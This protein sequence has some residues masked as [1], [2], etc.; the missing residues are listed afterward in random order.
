MRFL[1]LR[2]PARVLLA[3][4]FVAFAAVL[5]FFGLTRTQ[6][7]RDGL[8]GQIEQAFSK[9]FRGSIE[10]G[11][12]T[13]NLVYDLYATDVRLRDPQGRVVLE[14]DSVVLEPTWWGIIRRRLVLDE[15]TLI[16]PRIDLVR[17]ESGRWNLADVF[18]SRKPRTEPGDP[19]D[20]S[21]PAIWL[22]DATL[23]T[24]NEGDP[25]AAVRKGTLFDYTAATITH[26]DLRADLDWN[27]DRHRIRVRHLTAELTEPPLQI[28]RLEGILDVTDGDVRLR[29]LVLETDASQIAGDFSLVRSDDA[30]ALFDLSLAPSHVAGGELRR[31]VPALPLAD[32]VEIAA[33]VRGPLRDLTVE[34]LTLARGATDLRVEGTLT[35][36]PDSAVF[37]VTI[38][39]STVHQRD[40]DAVWPTLA[41]P[42]LHGLGTT[43]LQLDADGAY[44]SGR[45]RTNARFTVASDAGRARGTARLRH[46]PDRPLVY[47]LDAETDALDPGLLLGDSAWAGDVSGHVTLDGSGT[48]AESLNGRLQLA[49]AESRLAGRMIDTLTADVTTEGLR[50]SGSAVLVAGG[51]LGLDGTVDLTAAPRF[52][53]DLRADAFDL[54]RLLYGAPP[55]RLTADATLDGTGTTLDDFRGDLAVQFAPST[56]TFGGEARPI[57]AHATTLRLRPTDSEATWF[58]LDSDLVRVRGAGDVEAGALVALATQWTN[59]VARTVQTERA[60]YY[61]TRPDSLRGTV[62]PTTEPVDAAPQAL[63]VDVEIRQP[64]ALRALLPGFP[65]FAPGTALDV[66]AR[67]APDSLAL[68]ASARGDSLRVPGLFGSAF[69][70]TLDF[71]SGYSRTLLGRSRLDLDLDADTLRI[72]GGLPIG[73]TAA[74]RLRDREGTLSLRRSR[75]DAPG[76]LVLDADLAIRPDVNRLTLHLVEVAT[77]SQTWRERGTQTVDLYAD[78]IVLRD[79]VF[80]REQEG[81][82]PPRLAFDGVLSTLDT[83]S[84]HVDAEALD[85]SELFGLI[86]KGELFGGRLDAELA[87]VSALR[88]P[89]IVGAATIDRF[90]FAG[91]R[92]GQITLTSQYVPG[93]DGVAVDLHLMPD[94]DSLSVVN[95]LR[96]SGTVR[97]PGTRDDGSRDP[98]ALDL[99][100][101]L[102]RLD[103]FV[104]DWLFPS[105]IDDAGG[106]A[107][108]TGRITGV[109]RVPLFDANLRIH[110]GTFRVPD[111]GLQLAAEGRVTVD[112]EG[113]HIRN[114]HLTD[115]GGGQGLVRGDILFN[116]YRFFS[117]DLAA[118]LAELEIID[119][120]D[121]RDLPFYGYIRASGSATLTGPINNVFLRAPDAQTTSDSEMFIPVTQSGPAA[122]AGFLVFADSLG[123]EPEFEARRSLIAQRP[124]NERAFLEGLEMNLNIFAPP[125]S[126]VHLVFDPAIGDVITAVGSAQLQLGIREGEFLTFGTFDVARGDYLFT[127]GDVFTRRFELAEGGTLQWDGDPIDARLDLP[128]TYRTRASLAGLDLPGLDPRQRVPLVITLDVTGRVT[129]PL[130]DLSLALDETNRTVAGAEAL[131]RQLNQSD[132]QAQYATSV[133]LTNSFLL[134]PSENQQTIRDAAD[135][136]F[137]TSLSQLV[138]SRLNLFLNDALG[139][140]NV[141]VLFGVQQGAA[142]EDFDLTY[143]VALRLLDERLI[144]RGE[145]IYQRLQD[146]PVSEEL[147][148]EVAVEVRLTP[149]VSLEVFYRRE[150]DVLLG[151][152]LSATPYGAYG[153]GVNY[154]TDFANWPALL[155]RIIGEAAEER[156]EAAS[157]APF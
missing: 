74:F 23:T 144:I 108:G 134:A 96:A 69:A 18:A 154:E 46:H 141:D 86:G 153:A 104:F 59:A 114:A 145:G 35:G 29:D 32:A 99:A 87:V 13:G 58:D 137:F 128:A 83:D 135:E 30:P 150:G 55:T 20:L 26:L 140:Q 43:T 88:Q 25:P 54:R 16:R 7:G 64:D 117:F 72:M 62:A 80:E 115:K 151:S 15:A 120:P 111:F 97:L 67:L 78:A 112:R 124:E 107:A 118:D 91:R 101:D 68:T 57:P 44:S 9:Q 132:R 152:G 98:G 37:A 42:D 92:A 39:R 6:V 77:E 52:D 130:V 14:A 17:S 19:L 40:L 22:V 113:F 148:G 31:I 126:T 139:S 85:L 51:T 60:K 79:L 136:L 102:D 149:S 21:A 27:R 133:L 84:L 48:S 119:V 116:D 1:F 45:F 10:I 3:A 106:Y 157:A 125:G 155:R 66:Q 56:I 109:P 65:A 95:D 38:P 123:N 93:G 82:M 110:D 122:D 50:L 61:H 129:S 8:R 131:R 103:L 76:R 53:L 105:I 28:R 36:L 75:L 11:Q 90:V 73:T 143:G 142:P 33:E 156:D 49:L 89:A 147:Q 4:A 138:S 100:L 41:L 146:R 47:T 12:L 63:T 121:S 127:A 34:R 81:T 70:A 94:G 5:L 24:H 2:L 71:R